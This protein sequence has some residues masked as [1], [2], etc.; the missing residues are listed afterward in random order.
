MSVVIAAGAI[1]FRQQRNSCNLVLLPAQAGDHIE[2]FFAQGG[3][4]RRLPMGAGQ[5]R[6]VAVPL[7]KFRYRVNQFLYL[8]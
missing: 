1:D 4:G 5:H 7:S 2:Q 3:G 8:R 6:N